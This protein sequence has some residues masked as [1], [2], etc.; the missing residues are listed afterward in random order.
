MLLADVFTDYGGLIGAVAFGVAG[1][2]FGLVQRREATAARSEAKEL[3][4]RAQAEQVTAWAEKRVGDERPV[5]VSNGSGRPVFEVKAWL[6]PA[7][8]AGETLPDKPPTTRTEVLEG[9]EEHSYSV[10]TTGNPP[11]RRPRVVITFVDADGRAW[12]RTAD[13]QLVRR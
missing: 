5:V 4:E 7:D 13:R 8:H 12:L 11:A 9:S 6:V 10:T 2:V 3:R 1:I